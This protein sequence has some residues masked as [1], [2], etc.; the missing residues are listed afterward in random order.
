MPEKC[1]Y[2]D[3]IQAEVIQQTGENAKLKIR[4]REL[5]AENDQ[6]RTQLSTS[7]QGAYNHTSR[8][9]NN[10]ASRGPKIEEQ[11]ELEVNIYYTLINL[12]ELILPKNL[13]KKAN[14]KGS[15]FAVWHTCTIQSVNQILALLA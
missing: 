8:A 4:E 5:T 6:L 9:N 15:K 2:A 1:T 12:S 7:G 14:W 13:L 11:T 3:V 10:V